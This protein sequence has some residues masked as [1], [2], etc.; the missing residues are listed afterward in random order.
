LGLGYAGRAY[1]DLLV[2][3]AS[4][5]VISDSASDIRRRWRSNDTAGAREGW[6]TDDRDVGDRGP[7]A[8][9]CMKERRDDDFGGSGGDIGYSC[10]VICDRSLERRFVLDI[11]TRGD[12]KEA[13]EL[14]KG[15]L[16]DTGEPS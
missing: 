12:D 9:D 1:E 13:L 5:C 11:A 16:V 10:D 14:R 8:G 4:L 3:C 6:K 15:L 2:E 7:N